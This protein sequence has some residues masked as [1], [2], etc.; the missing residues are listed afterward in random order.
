MEELIKL[1]EEVKTDVNYEECEDLVDGGVFGSFEIIQM[2]TEIE[3]RFDV[4]IAASDIMAENFNS[5]KALWKMIER[6][7]EA[8]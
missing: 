2:I 8:E 5:A 3:D 4:A 1:L 6:L 7:R